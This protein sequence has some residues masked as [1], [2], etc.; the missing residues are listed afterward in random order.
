MMKDILIN[1][2]NF[3]NPL[4]PLFI[5]IVYLIAFVTVYLLNFKYKITN[6]RE[7]HES[8]DGLRGFLA[9]GVFIHH[10]SIWYKYLHT[11]NWETP[12]SNL[13]NQI[14]KTSVSFFF[15]ITAFLFISKLLNLNGKKFNWNTFFI[16]RIFRLIP[17]YLFSIL[18]VIVI[19]LTIGDWEIKVKLG[20]FLKEIL[21]WTTFTIFGAPKINA[22]DYTNIVNAGVVWS[23]PYEWLFYFSLPIIS[24]LIIKKASSKFYIIISILFILVFCRFKSINPHHILSF[25]GGAIS[26]LIIKYS[27]KK[28]NYNSFFFSIIILFFLSLIL[29]FKNPNNLICKTLILIIF[30]LIALGNNIFGILKSSILKFLGEISYSTYLIH[31][32]IIFFVMYFSIGF[33]NAANMSPIKFWITIFFITP[34]LIIISFIS[35]QKIEK[36]F[37]NFSKKI[38]ID[39]K[40]KALRNFRFRI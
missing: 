30:N 22:S 16:S 10:S 40:I 9:L 15:M 7:R 8:I 23:L 19:L 6:T 11:K 18:I 38:K 26:P 2:T 37:I 29:F 4:N 32:I 24:L 12:N 17:M 34:I 33:E 21:Y 1:I 25:A 3:N 27:K 36:P 35:Y 14:G 28:I 20:A 39:T 5:I 31:G 13:F